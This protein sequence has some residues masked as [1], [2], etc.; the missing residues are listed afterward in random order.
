MYLKR[1]ELNLVRMKERER[2]KHHQT[3]TTNGFLIC[4]I[5]NIANAHTHIKNTQKKQNIKQDL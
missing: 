4:N 5:F 3:T 2:K 1:N